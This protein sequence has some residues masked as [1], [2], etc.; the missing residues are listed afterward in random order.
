MQLAIRSSTAVSYVYFPLY[1][2]WFNQNRV[3]TFRVSVEYVH[4]GEL[5][6]LLDGQRKFMFQA[7]LDSYTHVLS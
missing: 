2:A 1:E 6:N 4:S 7:F 3:Y 5:T